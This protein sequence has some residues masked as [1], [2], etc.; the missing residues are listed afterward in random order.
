[1]V[2][3]TTLPAPVI[4]STL[5]D[6]SV[7]RPQ[8]A[9]AR[10]N[11]DALLAAGRIAFS[12]NGSDA[13]L[14][15][16][17]RRAGVGIGTLYRNFP[18]RESLIEALYLE[19]IAALV[20]VSTESTSLAPGDA[21]RA[22]IDRFVEYAHNKHA[23][24]DGLN[25][26]SDMFKQCRVVMYGAGEPVLQRAQAAGEI[27]WDASISDVLMLVS[28]VVGVNFSDDEQRERVM[29]LAMAGLRP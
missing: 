4:P 8:R 12:E 27:R 29:S 17:A 9:D 6:V 11:F 20:R 24:I 26:E 13:S 2:V 10:R 1:M 18:S 7:K 19:E 15:D 5:P 23:L 25:K 3:E 14:E 16:I 21:F 28:G 22:W